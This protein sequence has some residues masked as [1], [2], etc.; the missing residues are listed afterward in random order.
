MDVIAN[1]S[2]PFFGLVGV[3]WLAGRFKVLDQAAAT[4][5]NAF[6]YWFALP[7]MLFMKM[8]DAPLAEAFDWRFV[9]AYSGGGLL[10]FAAC[11]VLAR[12]LFHARLDAAAIQGMGAAFGN[13]GY[14]GLP[15]LLAVFGEKVLLPAVLVIALDHIFLL[16]I[17][18]ALI[19]IGGGRRTSV[20][21]VFGRVVQALVRNPLIV[22]TVAG[23]AWGGLH[24]PLPGPVGAFGNLLSAAAGP[25]ALFA[26][27]CT[28][29]G[30]SAGSRLPELMPM[31]LCKLILHPLLAFCIASALYLDPLLRAV[32]T[33][34]A[35]LPIAANVFIMARATGVYVE[36]ASAAILI[37]TVIAVFTVS[38]MLAWFAP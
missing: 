25:A 14:M 18:T 26:L 12:L 27:G 23:L 22:S 19:E 13:V 33:V 36:R 24:L 21:E 34:E 28:L 29:A 37:S 6:V 17:T 3:G 31:V 9:A 11:V 5:V 30:R 32:A 20:R 35:S 2:L 1:I 8:A 10:S 4:G 15:I 7:A 16:P 38:L